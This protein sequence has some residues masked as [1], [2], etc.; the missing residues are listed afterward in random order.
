VL[1]AQPVVDAQR[2]DLEVGEDAVHPRQDDMGGH[3]ADDMGIGC[4]AA[5]SIRRAEKTVGSAAAP[6]GNLIG[7]SGNVTRERRRKPRQVARGITK[8]PWSFSK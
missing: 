1:A 4:V 6:A 2:P 3:L 7:L 5:N 8:S